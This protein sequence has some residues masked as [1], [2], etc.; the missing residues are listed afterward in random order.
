MQVVWIYPYLFTVIN[1]EGVCHGLKRLQQIFFYDF[2]SLVERLICTYGSINKNQSVS[3]LH[4]ESYLKKKCCKKSVLV[5]KCIYI[6]LQNMF[7]QMHGKLCQ[8]ID[9]R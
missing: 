1:T 7:F 2:R 6:F 9:V 4:S 3:K 8:I 5:G